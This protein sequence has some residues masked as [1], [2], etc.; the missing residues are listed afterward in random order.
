VQDFEIFKSLRK[1]KTTK[2]AESVHIYQ[3]AKLVKEG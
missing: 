1:K 2:I 3:M